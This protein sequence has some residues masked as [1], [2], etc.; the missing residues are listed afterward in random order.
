MFDGVHTNGYALGMYVTSGCGQASTHRGPQTDSQV[1]Q[2][3]QVL[4]GF[5]AVSPSLVH[6]QVVNGGEWRLHRAFNPARPGLEFRCGEKWPVSHYTPVCAPYT[7]GSP[8]ILQ[9]GVCRLG[10]DFEWS[11]RGLRNVFDGHVASFWQ[12]CGPPML[13]KV[14]SGRQGGSSQDVMAGRSTRWRRLWDAKSPFGATHRGRGPS[15]GPDAGG[16]DG[17]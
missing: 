16:S 9:R 17:Q 13:I 15:G 5:P 6:D 4:S 8:Y 2:D 12:W 14:R 10:L 7:G 3:V 11:C 1:V